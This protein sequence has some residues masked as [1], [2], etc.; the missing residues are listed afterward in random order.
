MNIFIIGIQA[1]KTVILKQLFI[2]ENIFKKNFLV[3]ITSL[4]NNLKIKRSI[5]Y[6]KYLQ[7]VFY[8]VISLEELKQ[9]Q[10]IHESKNKKIIDYAS[11]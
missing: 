10:W 4:V 8:F 5:S 3:D 1:A 7:I 11:K 2:I 9:L 6:C